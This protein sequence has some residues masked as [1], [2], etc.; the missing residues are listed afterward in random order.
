MS[1]FYTSLK[2][3]LVPGGWVLT[4]DLVYY[5]SLLKCDVRV[6][7]G[8][9]TD[10]ASVPQLLSGLSLQPLERTVEPLWCMTSCATL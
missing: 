10:L 5:S 1:Y 2:T 4:Q 8:F 7:E 9:F 6:P 3:E